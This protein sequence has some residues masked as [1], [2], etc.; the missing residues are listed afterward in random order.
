M[1]ARRSL[2]LLLTCLLG[3][4]GARAASAQ[5]GGSGGGGAQPARGANACRPDRTP[6]LRCPD[7]ILRTPYDRYFE[8]VRGQIRYHAGNSI[9]NQGQG[10]A[11]V[12]GQ[13][14][15]TT[16]P[17]SVTQHIYGF[18]RRRYDFPSPRARIVF[19]FIPVLGP[20]WKFENAA[21]FELWS[22]DPQGHLLRLV[23]TG[24]KFIYCLR[25]L[26]KRLSLPFS[27][28]FR[29]YPACNQDPRRRSITLGTSVGWADEY[30]ASYYEQWID[31]TGLRGRFVF[32][33]RVDPLDGIRES[34]E[35]NNVSPRVFL[36]LPPAAAR[37]SGEPQY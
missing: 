3:A 18:D 10:P 28:P 11:E 31:V 5:T 19:K 30:P 24:P 22:V 16:G 2:A 35:T 29:H 27:P 8:R 36:R 37:R 9:V 32:L 20:Y 13:R 33:Q 6:R 7:L 17:M 12:F 4:F 1:P 21:R 34:N 23:R 25:D 14:A 15:T 26:R